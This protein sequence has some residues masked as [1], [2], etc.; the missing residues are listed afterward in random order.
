MKKNR[1]LLNETENILPDLI[2]N[3]I[4]LQKRIEIYNRCLQII[5]HF[6]PTIRYYV[7]RTDLIDTIY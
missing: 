1:N 4:S 6:Q 3:N 2:Q 5:E 7:Q